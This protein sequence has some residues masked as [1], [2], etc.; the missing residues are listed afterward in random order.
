MTDPDPVLHLGER[1]VLLDRLRVSGPEGE[2]PLT[3]REAALLRTL[4]RAEGPVSRRTLLTEVWDYHPDVETR[5]VHHTV[6][7]LR[8]KLEDDPGRPR[9]LITVRG[10]GYTLRTT[11]PETRDGLPS[12]HGRAQELATLRQACS[13]PGVVS[14]VGPG[15]VGK[16]RL[17]TALT[18]TW[19]GPWRFVRAEGFVDEEGLRHGIGEAIGASAR[20]LGPALAS[21]GPWL[22]VLDNLEQVLESASRLV[23]DLGAHAPELTLLTTSRRPLDLPG[24]KVL[25][26]G[27]LD[28]VDALALFRDRA[29]AVRP[30]T[31]SAELAPADLQAVVAAADGMP[32]AL[33]LAASR[34]RLLS[35]PDLVRRMHHDIRVLSTPDPK[36]PVRH[37][38][39]D[40]ALGGTWDGLPEQARHTL[41]CIS[42]VRGDLTLDAAEFVAGGSALDALD[43]LARDGLLRRHEDHLHVLVPIRTFA[44]TRLDDTPDRGREA[45]DRHAAWMARLGRPEALR[46]L[47][48]DP[49]ALAR[50]ARA[51]PDLV[52]A[53]DHAAST[54]NVPLAL[55]LGHALIEAH[56]AVADHAACVRVCER[57]AAM[58]LP[59]RASVA[60]RQRLA[61][62]LQQ[63]R[64][65]PEAIPVAESALQD[66]EAIEH[67]A[68]AARLAGLLTD[69]YEDESRGEEAREMLRQARA[70][71]AR[72]PE[73]H[74]EMLALSGRILAREGDAEGAGEAY[75]QAL[76]LLRAQ[77]R[78]SRACSVANNAAN[79]SRDLGRYSRAWPLYERALG[80][81]RAC[82]LRREEAVI[83]ANLGTAH[84]QSGQAVEG[85]ASLDEAL[86]LLR[87]IG[88]LHYEAIFLGVLSDFL[89]LEG[90]LDAAEAALERARLCHA[91][92][93]MDMWVTIVEARAAEV[94]WRRGEAERAISVLRRA[95]RALR[96]ALPHGHALFQG[97]LVL[98]LLAAGQIDEAAALD[99]IARQELRDG[100]WLQDL[101]SCAA[102]NAEALARAGRPQAAR[103]AR[104]DAEAVMAGMP[105]HNPWVAEI[106]G[107][108]R[109]LLRA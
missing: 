63:I 87:D 52:D 53:F 66:A 24:E 19:P 82:R 72:D 69:L 67:H 95:M 45:R 22:L 41:A 98:A 50:V 39:L 48:R 103:A 59:P 62:S 31:A 33:E 12:F 89:F 84:Y 13:R 4:A 101:L 14:V 57:L 44:R 38:S 3:P 8:R 47:E 32:L 80:L 42:L 68:E 23:A 28:E 76:D 16:T 43:Q 34:L 37:R 40:A 36:R 93:G 6:T 2:T 73:V 35:L 55:P 1:R 20:N 109:E 27:G 86:G 5:A 106:L 7:R 107:R 17:V 9:H 70:H 46:T 49:A 51:R 91:T 85:R 105:G 30:L 58:A 65:V 26:L 102:R 18:T 108:V 56:R 77:G 15:G 96:V 100:G 74:A 90:D 81:A 79:L 64:R 21:R 99:P 75:E 94:L 92:L 11:R 104:D 88:D 61:V 10:L 25:D 54:G 60:V 78:R 97:R 83:L 29:S 71:G